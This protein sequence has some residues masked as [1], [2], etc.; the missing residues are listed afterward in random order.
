MSESDTRVVR[1]S[2]E[3]QLRTNI[4]QDFFSILISVRVHFPVLTNPET[5]I[6]F[7]KIL[8]PWFPRF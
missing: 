3:E 6:S 5:S 4:T 7:T 2:A 8:F 1:V